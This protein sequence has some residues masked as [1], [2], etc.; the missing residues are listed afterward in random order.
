[1]KKEIKLVYVY[2]AKCFICNSNKKV[3]YTVA[4]FGD[5]PVIKKCSH[6]GELY[7]YALDDEVYIKSIDKQ[8]DGKK[9]KKCNAELLNS[10]VPTHKNIQC[11]GTEFSLDDDF[12]GYNIPSSAEMEPVDVYLIYS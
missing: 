12:I 10:L 5:A 4:D 3:Y 1:M 2:N 11:C 6:C 7:W 8:L 9:C